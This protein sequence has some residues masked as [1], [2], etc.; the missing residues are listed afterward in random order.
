[1]NGLFFAFLVAFSFWYIMQYPPN[2]PNGG[3]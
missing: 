3:L 2:R 1:M